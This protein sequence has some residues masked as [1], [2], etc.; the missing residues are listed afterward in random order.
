[1]H[2]AY[3]AEA[4]RYVAVTMNAVHEDNIKLFAKGFANTTTIGAY[5]P[6]P[7]G[8][9]NIRWIEGTAHGA[10]GVTAHK[11]VQLALISYS[12]ERCCL[13]PLAPCTDTPGVETTKYTQISILWASVC[14]FKVFITKKLWVHSRQ[15]SNAHLSKLY[16]FRVVAH[17]PIQQPSCTRK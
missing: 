15:F 3:S 1:M 11:R 8:R 12:L 6:V 13:A 17:L 10:T 16:T 5:A 14:C 4:H 9:K 7:R 2:S